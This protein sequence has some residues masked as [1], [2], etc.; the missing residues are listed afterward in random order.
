MEV[1]AASGP[2][3]LVSVAV[4][5]YNSA[6]WLPRALDS[7]LAQRTDFPIEIVIG[8]DCS[9][10]D[11]IAVANSYRERHPDRIRILERDRNIGIQRNYF[12]T[13][14][15]CRGK[16]IAWLDADDQWTDPEKLSLQIAALEADASINA[17]GHFVRW[18]DDAEQ[19]KRERYPEIAAGRYGLADILHRDFLPALS[20]VFRN[21]IHRSLPSWYFDIAPMTDWPIWVLAALSGQILMLDRI[22]ADYRITPGSAMIS[23]GEL[24]WYQTDAR[25][26]EYIQ[27]ILPPQWQRL[28]RAEKGKRYESIAYLLRKQGD[29]IG[30][31]HAAVRAFKSPFPTDRIGTKTKSLIASIL[32]EAEWRFQREKSSG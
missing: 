23:K 17:C 4:T 3:P 28:V 27:T 9:K 30:S 32:R 20:V 2:A 18:V 7:I 12:E 10:D 29:Y 15:Q 16:Y 25:F 21:G 1:P 19:V 31:R 24:Y 5:A 13:F 26:Y 11:T 22:M 6:P 14:E 8:D